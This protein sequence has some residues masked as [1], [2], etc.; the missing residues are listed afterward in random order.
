[1]ARLKTG[2]QKLPIAKRKK[3]AYKL[4]IQG[5]S[6]RNIADAAGLGEST[7]QKCAKAGDWQEARDRVLQETKRGAQAQAI[8]ES[9]EFTID[10]SR[11]QKGLYEKLATA[12]PGTYEGIVREIRELEMLKIKKR[13]LGGERNEAMLLTGDDILLAIRRTNAEQGKQLGKTNDT[14]SA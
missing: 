6:I 13:L 2:N 9:I 8:K 5:E 10:I 7:V 14:N 4:Y 1:M 3:I 12:R 11:L